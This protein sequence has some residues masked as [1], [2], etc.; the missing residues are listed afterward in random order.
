MKAKE[1]LGEDAELVL[2]DAR[3]DS[4]N[5]VVKTSLIKGERKW[6][7]SD[8][9][10]KVFLNKYVGIPAFFALLWA[11]FQFTFKVSTP[12]MAMI[13][14]FFKWLT[15]YAALIPNDIVAS[16][17]GDGIFG[18]LGFILQFTVPI[19]FL[20]FALAILEDSGYLTRVAFVFDRLLFKLGLHGRSFIPML[21][22]FGCNVPAIMAARSIEGKKDRLITILIAPFMS[23]AARLPVYVLI[24]GAFFATNAATAVWSMY[25][26]GIFVAIVFALLLRKTILRGDPAPFIVELP[27]Y[28]MPTLKGA[29][30]H[31]WERGVSF[32]KKAGT[33]LLVGA[34]IIW[35]LSVLPWGVTPGSG[36]SL[37]GMIGQTIQ[38][39]FA[40]LGFSWQISGS[41]IFAF[42]AKEVLVESL[43]VIYSVSSDVG[44]QAALVNS[45]TP[46]SAYALMVFMLLYVPCL[47][48]IGVIKKETNSWKWTAF[49][50][51]SQCVIA[52]LGALIVVGVGT[53]LGL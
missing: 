38:P 18:G 36:E 7:A 5:K 6:S 41:L 16:V 3:Y 21:I 11:V 48:T 8:L 46:L 13:D 33:Y 34:I 27:T 28:K 30:L 23:C 22:G 14:M 29:V 50:A 2:A 52:Y 31:M 44:I 10:D 4:I 39:V 12:F 17:I 24:A 1:I 9:L 53:L 47:A 15:G 51:V 35:S 25:L 32:L 43:G 42:M 26:I 19:F 45:I 20:F 40:P 49:S 37:I